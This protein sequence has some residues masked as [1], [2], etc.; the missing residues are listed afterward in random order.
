MRPDGQATSVAVALATAKARPQ[1]VVLYRQD[2]AAAST[3]KEALGRRGFEVRSAAMFSDL[4]GWLLLYGYSAVVV[5]ELPSIDTFRKA[6]LKEA[7]RVGQGVPVVALT[8]VVTSDVERDAEAA[9]VV[10]VLPTD[11]DP[12]E[13]ATAV[14]L[15]CEDAHSKGITAKNQPSDGEVE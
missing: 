8:K 9:C 6:V 10:R 2:L 13:I 11:A 12:E 1:R 14:E 7:R 5:L 3:L 15:A 4:G